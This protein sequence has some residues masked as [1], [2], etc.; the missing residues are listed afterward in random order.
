MLLIFT[1]LRSAV[2]WRRRTGSRRSKVG[3]K[4]RMYSWSWLCRVLVG[5][6]RSERLRWCVFAMRIRENK[7]SQFYIMTKME[8]TSF[9]KWKQ[10]CTK[11]RCR[12]Y[13]CVK[14]EL[15]TPYTSIVSGQ[16]KKSIFFLNRQHF[17]F[18]TT[19]AG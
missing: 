3:Y 7:R 6:T 9:S 12:G 16:T 18:G 11:S 19:F 10:M 5:R 14:K 15:R 4:Q 13:Y 8:I 17:W 2:E 1:L